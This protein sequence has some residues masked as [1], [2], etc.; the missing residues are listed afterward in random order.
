MHADTEPRVEVGILSAPVLRAF[1]QGDYQLS[2]E[3]DTATER[4]PCPAGEQEW[5]LSDGRLIYKGREYHSLLFRPLHP[6]SDCFALKDVTIGIHFHWERQETQYFRGSLKI[7][8]DGDRLTAINILPVEEYLL[9]VIASEMNAD[10]SLHL[11]KAHA[12][13]SRSWLLAQMEHRT[14][15]RKPSAPC[16]ESTD[17]DTRIL[18]FDHEEHTRFDVCADDHCQRYQGIARA[19]TP[20]VRQAIGETRGEILCYDGQICDARFSKCCGG[21]TEQFSTCWD[22]HEEPYLK[23]TRDSLTDSR[24][25][26]LTT[27]EGAE[28]WIR[29]TPEACCNLHDA[30]VISQILN[31]YDRETPDFFRWKVRYTQE[32]LSALVARKTG[33]SLGLVQQLVPLRRGPSGRISLL[34]IDGSLRSL[35]IGKELFIRQA[36]SKSHLYSSAFV[37]SREG[38]DFILHGAGWGHG[39]GLCQI[40]AAAMGARGVDYRKIL[41]HY[42]PGAEIR[43]LPYGR[44]P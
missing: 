20:Q 37:V 43:K 1:F 6:E 12:V 30:A 41:T 23:A 8:P 39:V 28:K 17:P 26:D 14:R 40:G 5:Q 18:W 44:T 10:S 19:C 33:T 13:I 27:E 4:T 3:T 22:N 32:E 2:A 36:L 24:L 11:L 25:P 16:P 31:G 7:I 29:S 35:T 9:S 15:P 42:Y 38:S 21:V 34:R